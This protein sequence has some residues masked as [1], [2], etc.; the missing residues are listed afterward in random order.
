MT[1]EHSTRPAAWD[2]LLRR[3][4]GDP[5]FVGWALACVGGDDAVLAARL[6]CPPANLPRLALCRRPD[7][8]SGRF[9]EEV[10]RIAAHA[11][12][13]A[14][15]LRDLLREATTVERLRGPTGGDDVGAGLLLAARDRER[16]ELNQERG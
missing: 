5:G 2:A 7:G 15:R 6:G 11:G 3:V 8:S 16:G 1:D 4:A 13:D 9:A 10:R 12:C 14:G